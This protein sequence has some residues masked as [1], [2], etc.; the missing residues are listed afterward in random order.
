MSTVIRNEVSKKNRYYIPKHRMLEL[1]HFCLQ[2]EDWRK[3]RSKITVIQS[4]QIGKI[5]GGG[6][7][8]KVSS[9]AMRA[10]ELDGYAELVVRC[11]KEADDYIWKW[12][13]EGVTSGVSYGALQARG[14]PCG[15][16]YYYDRYR[17]FFWL[18]DKVR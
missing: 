10:A 14:I 12:L 1:K 13:F 11:C 17:K 2:Y 15:K 9:L 16:D 3:E 6:N 8:D 18:L 7:P 5:P 4:Y